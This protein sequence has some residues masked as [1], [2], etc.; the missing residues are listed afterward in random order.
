MRIR[1]E[2]RSV[3]GHLSQTVAGTARR[4][5]VT[6]LLHLTP[7][8]TADQAATKKEEKKKEK[9][10]FGLSVE[11]ACWGREGTFSGVLSFR[12]FNASLYNS[13]SSVA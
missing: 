6:D 9:E 4:A 13:R 7:A 2:A 8:S 5:Y 11:F 10:R 1:T 3:E 12:D